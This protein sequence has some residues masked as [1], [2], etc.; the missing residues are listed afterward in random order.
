MD[1]IKK[2]FIPLKGSKS[3]NNILV[4]CKSS[5]ANSTEE[6]KAE[7]YTSCL[8]SHGFWPESKSIRK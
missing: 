2:Y 1:L 6:R 8:E 7:D 5:L 4:E 3:N